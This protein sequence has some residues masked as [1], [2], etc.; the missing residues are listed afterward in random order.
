MRIII[1]YPVCAVGWHLITARKRENLRALVDW[2]TKTPH[3]HRVPS[4]WVDPGDSAVG[5]KYTSALISLQFHLIRLPLA[6]FPLSDCSGET[7]PTYI[8]LPFP[9]TNESPLCCKAHL[10]KHLSKN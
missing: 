3:N 4:D 10:F 9:Q 2:G 6:D 8:Y 5:T 7:R 1:W